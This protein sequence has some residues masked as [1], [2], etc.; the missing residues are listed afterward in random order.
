LWSLP[1]GAPADELPGSIVAAQ[2]AGLG[3]ALH[4]FQAA[5]R[6]TWSHAPRL[7]L[8]T[9]GVQTPYADP[10]RAA[11][12]Q[13]PLWGLG[14]V[15]GAEHPD[16]WG[17]L[18]D[19]DPSLAPPA[20][21]AAL[22][23]DL[24]QP[25][26][27]D[28]LVIGAGTRFVS[29]LV[30]LVPSTTE[31]AAWRL[32]TDAAYLITGGLGGLGLLLAHWLADQGARRLILMGRTPLPPRNQWAEIDPAGKLGQQ[33]TAV[34]S[35][36]A[37]GLAV[38]LAA[39]DVGNEAQL[40]AFLAQY[41]Q[42][43]WPPIRGVMHAAAA[44]RFGLLANLTWP[45]MVEALHAKVDGG[46]LLHKLLPDLDFFVLFSSV[47]SLLGQTGQG[48]YAAAN[49]FLDA[50]ARHRSRQG[51]PVLSINWA[52]WTETGIAAFES[53]N[54]VTERLAQQGVGAIDPPAGF[55][56]L[57]QLLDITSL[58]ESAVL[59]TVTPTAAALPRLLRERPARQT[60]TAQQATA[61]QPDGPPAKTTESP[62]ALLRALEPEERRP[63]LAAYLQGAVGQVLRL[64]PS[65]VG[66]TVALGSLGLDSLMA[67][68]LRNRLEAGLEISLPATFAW[69]YPTIREMLPYLAGRMNLALEDTPPA[70][71][72]LVQPVMEQNG[73]AE[74]DAAGVDSLDQ[75]LA[76]IQDLTDESVLELL[77]TQP[78]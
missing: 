28:E 52:V 14:R 8:V 41:A 23:P 29:R 27:A 42:E 49:A 12:Q 45:D 53:S 30:P 40:T 65:R 67:L 3:S 1:A 10:S 31:R 63:R 72:P 46:W 19:L 6:R 47:A 18:I 5:G 26:G 51:L 17:G 69:N 55:A 50:L 48:N 7:W 34:R 4:L 25:T 70:A 38:H 39:V 62:A 2:E 33:I 44:V 9:R 59:P 20:A 78:R 32:R 76:G 60:S 36:E 35:L 15:L 61:A 16:L 57:R 77:K 11:L 68:E 13:S 54:Q 24:S 66:L 71:L 74:P 64:S 58:T 56:V 43:G 22:W 73:A 75:L 37:K 21:A